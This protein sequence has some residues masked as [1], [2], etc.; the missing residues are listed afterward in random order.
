MASTIAGLKWRQAYGNE[1]H[2]CDEKDCPGKKCQYNALCGGGCDKILAPSVGIFCLARSGK[3]ITVCSDCMED[4]KPA[5]V[6]EGKWTVDG[7][8]M[9]VYCAD[10]STNVCD[11]CSAFKTSDGG[12]M[13]DS[14]VEEKGHRIK[15]MG[16]EKLLCNG[17]FEGLSL[18]KISTPEESQTTEK[19]SAPSGGAAAPDAKKKATFV[20]ATYNVQDRFR[21]PKGIDLDAPGVD[22][23]I[24]WC[25]L[26]ITKDG[27][28]LPKIEGDW[29]P[30][31]SYDWKRPNDEEIVEET[32]DEEDSSKGDCGDCHGATGAEMT[33]DGTGLCIECR[34]GADLPKEDE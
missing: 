4:I 31:Q 15:I 18:D 7:E 19:T 28:D 1:S 11:A 20:Y 22:W 33:T 26:H 32:D 10:Q 21:V 29:Q 6:G 9:C 30:W 5:M 3:E 25:H 16:A 2:D 8:P 17:C 24:K 23:G 13:C 34:K 14:C 27:V 12:A